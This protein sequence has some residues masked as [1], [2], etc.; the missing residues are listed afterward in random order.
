M[1][2]Y[3]F[4]TMPEQIPQDKIAS[5][6]KVET[7]TVGHYLHDRFMRNDLRPVFKSSRI[8][9]TA[10]TVSIPG[11]DSTLLYHVMDRVRPGDILIIDRGGDQKHAPWGG[12]MSE[13]ARIRGLAGVIVDGVVT[14]PASITQSGVPTWACGVSAIT[15]KLMNF[16]G[17][18]NIPVS[19]GGVAVN[20]GDVVI[21]DDCGIVVLPPD[22]VDYMMQIALKDQ[23]EESDWIEQL[24]QGAKLQDLIDIAS[25]IETRN[26]KDLD[27]NV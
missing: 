5:L 23:A 16:G 4:G 14:D 18:F 19:V 8:A 27:A 15:T 17:A 20:P 24:S 12:F 25:M 26:Q 10:V 2:S 3:R 7:A 22:E 13:V 21:A 11:P 1:K 6:V 9:G